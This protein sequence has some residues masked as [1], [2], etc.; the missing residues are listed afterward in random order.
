MSWN[1]QREEQKKGGD[2]KD[3]P[4]L[5]VSLKPENFVPGLLIGFF[6]GLFVDLSTAAVRGVGRRGASI[7]R[8]NRGVDGDLKMVGVKI[9]RTL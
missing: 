7:T 6:L 4:W 9:G 1:R 3:K 5:S 8:S 2:E